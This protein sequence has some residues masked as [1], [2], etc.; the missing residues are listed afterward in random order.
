[1]RDPNGKVPLGF[2]GVTEVVCDIVYCILYI[3][4]SEQKGLMICQKALNLQCVIR[5]PTP[6]R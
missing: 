5:A 4:C 2:A 1:M 3:V 6:W